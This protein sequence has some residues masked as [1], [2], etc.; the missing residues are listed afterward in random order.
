MRRLTAVEW[1]NTLRDLLGRLPP[2]LPSLPPDGTSPGS[3]EN[4]ALALGPSDVHVSRWEQAA[5][6][7]GE[8]VA[9]DPTT[10]AALVPC[11]EAE[12]GCARRFVE[13]FGRRALRRPLTSEEVGRYTTFFE[14]QRAEIDFDA[15]IQLTVSAFLQSPQFLYRL[16]LGAD[17]GRGGHVPLTPHEVASRLSYLLWESMPDD[18]LLAAADARELQTPAQL[19]AQTR[20]MLADPR[21]RA[22]TRDY[23][24]QWLHL[25][26]VAS[27]AKLPEVVPEWSPA[28]A[29]AAREESLRFAE[30]VFYEGSLSDLFTS[31]T[32]F[33][34]PELASIYGVAPSS[35]AIELPPERAG[36]LTR[37]GFLAGE[38]REANGSPPLRG[39]F[40]LSRLLCANIGAPPADAD[41]SPP[42]VDETMGPQTN[43][44]LFEERTSPAACQSCH[45]RIDGIGFGFENYDT[46]GRFR[47][48]DNGLPVDA[49]GY[50]IGI[51]NDGIYDGAVELQQLFAES[52]VVH[53]CA[54]QKYFV[55][56]HGRPTEREDA[57]HLQGLQ[58]AFRDSGGDL[59]ELLVHM[60][61]RPEFLLR[62]EITE[63]E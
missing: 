51:G 42:R 11:G 4:E 48:T 38:A 49:V 29:A 41:T 63:G 54:V 10:R 35:E 9:T 45:E 40:V 14:A 21:A 34:P 2:E 60:V 13:S 28:V 27:E 8:L 31:R 59:D 6:A 7:A 3:F 50:A 37:V 20:R 44:M 52:P 16:E 36:I 47:T 32:G 17:A 25:D 33:V 5:F 39:V 1:S 43:R 15:A 53:D 30:H 26:R 12:A 46:A 62:P 24:R 18:A 56:A 57:C 55:Y 58:R 19:A 61:T 22:A 23:F